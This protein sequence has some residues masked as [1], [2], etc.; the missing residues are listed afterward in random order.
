MDFEAVWGDGTLKLRCASHNTSNDGVRYADCNIEDAM[1]WGG[2]VE[3][4]CLLCRGRVPV[5]I[6][7]PKERRTLHSGKCAFPDLVG[8]APR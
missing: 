4:V 7:R 2:D 5:A 1:C 6:T 8:T 3:D